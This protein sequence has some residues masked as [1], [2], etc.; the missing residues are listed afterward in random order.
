MLH[1]G[2]LEGPQAPMWSQRALC[3]LVQEAEDSA[4]EQTL[5]Q[6]SQTLEAQ[7]EVLEV[8]VEVLEVL[9]G[10]LEVPVE[11]SEVPVEVL[12][13]LAEVVVAAQLPMNNNAPQL[14]SSN[15]PL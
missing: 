9:V 7:A 2:A 3:R 11:V 12:E 15:A 5:A 1:P 4:M 8:P 6:L 10:V 14:M 13:V